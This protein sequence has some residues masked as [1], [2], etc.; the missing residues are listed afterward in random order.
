[1]LRVDLDVF[2]LRVLPPTLRWHGCDCS[3]EDLQQRLLHALTRYVASDRRVVR[4]ASD[5]VDLVDV[6]DPALALGDV[7]F[8]RLQQANEDVLDV[9]THV[10][11]FG[12][13]RR[14][15]DRERYLEDACE[16]LREK[17]FA[18]A[19]RAQQ[20]DVRLLDLYVVHQV[21]VID[22]LVVVVDGD[23]QGLLGELLADHVEVEDI[24]DVRGE[25]NL[26]KAPSC[27]AILFLREDLVA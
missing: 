3:F 19:R 17:R 15:R 1:M 9:F 26:G 18:D 20:H 24:L 12:E 22:P 5:L 16:R 11:G 10:A 6:D 8:P 21:T 4:L 23:G 25:R 2:L 27:F 7:V 14:I 13:R